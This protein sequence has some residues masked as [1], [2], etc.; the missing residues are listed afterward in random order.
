MSHPKFFLKDDGVDVG[1][2]NDAGAFVIEKKVVKDVL[3]FE[4]VVPPRGDD[5]APAYEYVDR[6]K[7]EHIMQY[8]DAYKAFKKANPE[9]KLEWPE[10]DID[11]SE[12]VA[13][14]AEEVLEENT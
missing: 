10:L 1:G 9:Y 8:K 12:P 5:K 7:K 14:I 3:F 13:P 2:Y 4:L 11:V 6:A